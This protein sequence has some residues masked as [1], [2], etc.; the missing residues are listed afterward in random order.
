MALDFDKGFDISVDVQI[1]ASPTSP[2]KEAGFFFNTGTGSDSQFIITTDNGE[3]AAF[4][5][6]SPKASN[7]GNQGP[8][9]LEWE[10]LSYTAGST[11][12]LRI[13]YL[14]PTLDAGTGAV[15]DA[16]TMQYWYN[17]VA[18]YDEPEPFGDTGL[19]FLPPNTRLALKMQTQATDFN[20]DTTTA[21][22][23]FSNLLIVE[24]VVGILGDF[25]D[26]GQVEQGD[27]D[28]VLQNWGDNT[29]ITGIP[30]GWTN[31]NT[32]LGQIEQTELDRVLQNW[33]ST[34]APDFQSSA[35]PEPATLA[36]LLLTGVGLGRR[37]R[38]AVSC[39]GFSG[40][41]VLK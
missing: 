37:G 24:P 32:D 29:A 21:S 34:S 28:L 8:D 26:S 23:I 35:V 19:Q 17:G 16:A 41:G 30:T 36:V 12:T 15:I 3:I 10:G 25:N 5:G 14:P 33:G 38:R 39:H 7:I 9:G 40:S 4:A 20:N 13:A 22:F 2:R 18:A 1:S 31:D 6:P 27:L 11:A